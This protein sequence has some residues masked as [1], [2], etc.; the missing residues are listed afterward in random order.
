MPQPTAGEVHV[1]KP[2]T[3][4]LVAFAQGEEGFVHNKVFPDVPVA[5]QSDLY[6]T[7][8]RDAW[9]RSDA[10]VRAPATESAGSGFNYGQDTYSA[11][12]RSLHK[13]IDDQ[14]R[15]NQ[16]APL[17]LDRDSTAWL[18]HQM[19][20]KREI[21]WAAAYFT[22][23]TWTGSVGGG[24]ITPG[25][26]WDAA[27]STPF[28][29]IRTQM[30]S[31]R[32]KTGFKPNKLVLGSRTWDAIVDNADILSRVTGGATNANPAR[33]NE[34]LVAQ[35]LG[36][37]E[38]LVAEAVQNTAIEGATLSMSAILGGN[39]ALLVYAAPRP[40]ILLPSAGYNFVWSGF[41]GNAAG[42]RMKRFRMEHL[43]A[44]RLEAEA[45]YDFKLVAADL[46][47]FFLNAVT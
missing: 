23:S 16:D 36:L 20:L 31:V 28:A 6:F 7:I 33:V 18:A 25:T 43:S 40:S 11:L 35:I 47:V 42:M 37:E 21:D 19:M 46:G 2:L 9:F 15:A 27:N 29:D 10:A 13:D 17:D 32:D 41:A 12:A 14:I 8:P 1:N 30:R 5:K 38:V 44:D 34:Q 3:N 4:T 45:A 22:T 26:L 39:D 24:D